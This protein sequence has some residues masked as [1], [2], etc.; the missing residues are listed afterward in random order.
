MLGFYKKSADNRRDTTTRVQIEQCSI[1]ES[2]LQIPRHGVGHD[3]TGRCRHLDT[4]ILLPV[5]L[6]ART[7]GLCAPRPMRRP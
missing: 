4:S 1:V 5:F 3:P 7:P 6:L 2:V